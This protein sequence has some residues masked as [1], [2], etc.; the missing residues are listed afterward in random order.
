MRF[1]VSWKIIHPCV[2][3][4]VG[5]RYAAD[6]VKRSCVNENGTGS[7]KQSCLVQVIGAADGDQI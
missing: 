6:T 7:E 1:S 4:I 2:I 3:V 5:C